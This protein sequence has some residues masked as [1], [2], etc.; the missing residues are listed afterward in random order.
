MRKSYQ[1]TVLCLSAY[2]AIGIF[3]SHS[4]KLLVKPLNKFTNQ[5]YKCVDSRENLK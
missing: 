5:T 4:N 2:S 3:R 1:M